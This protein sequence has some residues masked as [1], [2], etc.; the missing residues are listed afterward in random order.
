MTTIPQV[1]HAMREI[2]TTV[3]GAAA[4]TTRFVLRRSPLSGATFSQTLVFGFLGNPEASL[5]ELTQT[6]AALGVVVTPQ[7]LDQRFTE[8][9]AACLKQVLHAALARVVTADPLAIPLLA[10]FTAVALQDSSTIVLPAVLAPVW[11]VGRPRCR[12]SSRSG[13]CA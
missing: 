13:L 12:A 5:E 6:A 1:A 10:R 4:R 11:Q 8:A 9:A 3:A 2:L 7:A